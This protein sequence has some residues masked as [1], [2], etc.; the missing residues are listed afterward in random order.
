[1]IVFLHATA[2]GKPVWLCEDLRR[3]I[4]SF[5]NVKHCQRCHCVVSSGRP[6]D[7]VHMCIT[8]SGIFCFTCWHRVRHPL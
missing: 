2:A 4:H 7:R 3:H 5:A 6:N 8:R 1:M